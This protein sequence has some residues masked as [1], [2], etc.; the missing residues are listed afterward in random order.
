MPV[1]NLVTDMPLLQSKKLQSKK[2]AVKHGLMRYW[3][4]GVTI[5]NI[6]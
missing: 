5:A 2:V 1:L 3:P 6:E 4:N